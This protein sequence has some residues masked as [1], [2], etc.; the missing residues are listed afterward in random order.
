MEKYLQLLPNTKSKLSIHAL[1]QMALSDPAVYN[2][3]NELSA[4][5]TPTL[6]GSDHD[7]FVIRTLDLFAYGTYQ[8]YNH[9]AGGQERDVFNLTNE[10]KDKLRALTVATLVSRSLEGEEDHTTAGT[11]TRS[12]LSTI[13]DNGGGK[14]TRGVVPYSVLREGLGFTCNR[15]K[16]GDGG[17]CLRE[18]EYVLIKCIYA[19]LIPRGSRLDQRS[20]SLIVRPDPSPSLVNDVT[21]V[22]D[23]RKE[24]IPSMIK[25]LERL[26]ETGGRLNSLLT[27]QFGNNTK[28][29]AVGITGNM[30]WADRKRWA[31]VEGTIHQTEKNAKNIS[32]PSRLGD[33]ASSSLPSVA[34]VGDGRSMDE[35][36]LTMSGRK[37]MKRS[38]GGVPP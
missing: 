11:G 18:I 34:L 22:R 36:Q 14:Y 13:Q 30:I 3:F 37:H 33:I 25:V 28:K 21:V 2:G 1:I 38:R 12:C 35:M 31:D 23:V 15:N 26:V 8:D 32:M 16:S 7:A 4:L 29:N 6:S 19:G 17:E 24:D 20:S 10:Q 5:V 27:M 9:Y